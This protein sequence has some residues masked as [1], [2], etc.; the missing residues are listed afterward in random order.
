MVNF[1]DLLSILQ[2]EFCPRSIRTLV[3]LTLE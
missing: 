1:Y 2:I 3:S